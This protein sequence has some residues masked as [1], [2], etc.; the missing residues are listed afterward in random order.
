MSHVSPVDTT[1]SQQEPQIGPPIAPITGANQGMDKQVAKELVSDGV[2]VFIGSCGLARIEAIAAKIGD[3]A[4]AL[5]LD[6]T[7][8][9]SIA[10]TAERIRQEA[11]R[12]DLL[13]NNAAT[14]TARVY[15]R[16]LADRRNPK[17]HNHRPIPR[18]RSNR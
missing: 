16:S 8:A 17:Q 3:G 15:S 11:G 14:S 2:T 7:D 10:S 9:S 18:S 1:A 6:V 13:V 5:Q 4:I 12:L